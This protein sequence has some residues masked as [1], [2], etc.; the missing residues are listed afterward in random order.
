MRNLLHKTCLVRD[1]KAIEWGY[2]TP[3]VNLSCQYGFM[4]ILIR[5]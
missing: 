3:M 2:F 5:D 1:C 4:N